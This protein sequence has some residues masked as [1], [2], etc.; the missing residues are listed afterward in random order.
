MKLNDV[1]YLRKKAEQ[2]KINS[3]HDWC[4]AE[5]ITY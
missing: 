2:N 5:N 4:L 3:E 1:K